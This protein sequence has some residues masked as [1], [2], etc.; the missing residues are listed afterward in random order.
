[1]GKS[2]DGASGTAVR[3]RRF[4]DGARVEQ[5]AGLRRRCGCRRRALA[6]NGGMGRGAGAGDGAKLTGQSRRGTGAE[7]SW[8]R[9]RAPADSGAV[10]RGAGLTTETSWPAAEGLGAV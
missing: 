3:V 6:G 1:M 10:G 5:A 9:R 2:R 8:R 7:G 4:G